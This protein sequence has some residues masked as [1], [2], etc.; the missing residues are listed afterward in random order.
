MMSAIILECLPFPLGKQGVVTKVT[1]EMGEWAGELAGRLVDHYSAIGP[2]NHEE[3]V[4]ELSTTALGDYK[5]AAAA[6]A[7]QLDQSGRPEDTAKAN[8]RFS[9]IIKATKKQFANKGGF[10]SPYAKPKT[11]SSSMSSV[12]RQA[13]KSSSFASK[14]SYSKAKS[15]STKSASSSKAKSA[16]SFRNSKSTTSRGVSRGK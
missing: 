8:K 5:T 14:S 3:P 6:H 10:K 13:Q 7:G 1:K 11:G 4:T 2:R 16:G 12:S 9:G 15:G